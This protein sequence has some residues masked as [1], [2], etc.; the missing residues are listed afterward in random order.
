[1]NS[2][3]IVNEQD[4]L[5]KFTKG[6]IVS[7]QPVPDSPMDT[8]EIVVAMAK[9]AVAGG[10]VGLRIEGAERVRAVHNE[11]KVPIIG[12]VKRDL[13][14]S[15]VRITPFLDDVQA[16]ADAGA[17]VIAFDGTDRERPVP[18]AELLAKVHQ[19]GC[20][21]MAD[22]ADVASAK[23]LAE[24]G[25]TF[26]GT[27]LSGYLGGPVPDEPDFELLQNFVQL[28]LNVVAEGRYNTPQLAAQ[29]IK[30]G[31]LCVTV[32]SAITR[33]EHI[34]GWFADKIQSV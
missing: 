26:I 7:C 6:L 14:E 18:T 34:T 19:L 31:A 20:I 25:C 1:M 33:L 23:T 29:A 32:G 24:Q 3:N 9:A 13:V 21:A 22:C 5:K 16:L 30:L 28:G 10:A 2:K 11:V 15:D 8:N 27:T 17:A 12:I 4:L